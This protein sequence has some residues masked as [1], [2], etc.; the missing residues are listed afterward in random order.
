V[1]EELTEK[2]ALDAARKLLGCEE[3]W[4]TN[5]QVTV[6]ELADRL[7]SLFHAPKAW[8]PR[9]PP[10][11]R[12]YCPDCRAKRQFLIVDNSVLRPLLGPPPSSPSANETSVDLLCKRCRLVL[13]T[14]FRA[15]P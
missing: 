7:R 5:D 10:G 12:V 1:A 2:D 14:L 3:T 11:T 6:A 9:L 8:P 15:E 4:Q 13:L